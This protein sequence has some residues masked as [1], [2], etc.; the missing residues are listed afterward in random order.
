[1]EQRGEYLFAVT[2]LARGIMKRKNLVSP[3]AHVTATMALAFETAIEESC[4]NHLQ[5]TIAHLERPARGELPVNLLKPRGG[6]L[7]ASGVVQSSDTVTG[8][9]NWSGSER[10]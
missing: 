4:R 9:V 6:R 8:L 2:A 5:R 1:M 7:Q 10:S 3:E